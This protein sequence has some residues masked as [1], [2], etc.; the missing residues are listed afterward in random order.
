MAQP[1]H[2]ARRATTTAASFTGS[3]CP[4]TLGPGLLLRKTRV[5]P[6]SHPLPSE[7]PTSPDPLRKEIHQNPPTMGAPDQ[8]TRPEDQT[9]VTQLQ[10]QR[11]PFQ[12]CKEKAQAWTGLDSMGRSTVMKALG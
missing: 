6:R 4:G 9:L 8:M 11:G 3:G 5:S 2:C 1:H 10:S 7:H 12:N